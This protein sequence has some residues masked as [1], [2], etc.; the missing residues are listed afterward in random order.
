MEYTSYQFTASQLW[1]HPFC[2]AL[3]YWKLDPVNISS[4]PIGIM[5]SFVNRE[6]WGNKGGGRGFS[7]W[8]LW[9][10]PRLFLQYTADSSMRGIGWCSPPASSNSTQEAASQRI[11]LAPC[12]H[13]LVYGIPLDNFSTTKWA[14]AVLSPKRPGSHI[15]GKKESSH[16]CMPS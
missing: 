9:A 10:P 8:F 6:C 1:I 5:L 12:E 13:P 14:K 16:K 3:W 2:P 7:S 4:S 11:L 15:W